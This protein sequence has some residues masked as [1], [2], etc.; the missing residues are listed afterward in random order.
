[1]EQTKIGI[2]GCGWLG[3]PLAEF[4]ISKNYLIKGSTKTRKKLTD[5]ENKSI[6]PFLIDLPE[7]IS[8]TNNSDFFNSE[9]LII[10]IPPIDKNYN[11]NIFPHDRIIKILTEKINSSSV[12]KVIYI[13][14][15]SVYRNNNSIITEES[16]YDTS[17][18]ARTLLNA[19][20]L[21]QKSR[22]NTT[23]LR[24]GG[25]YGYGR[26]PIRKNTNPV[27]LDNYRKLNLLHRDN[28]CNVILEIIE[29]NLWDETF[30]VCEDEHP[31]QLEFFHQSTAS[32]EIDNYKID[33]SKKDYKI[34][35]NFKLRNELGISLTDKISQS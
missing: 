2:L 6:I 20:S 12:K 30:N 14:S 8:N 5:L 13:S 18:R 35:S 28:G 32:S 3:L 4:L 29:K 21:L 31:T 9:I 16:D 1:M 25:L 24:F 22:F 19:E 17:L 26:I 23:V 10:N 7:G 15:T 27:I 33:N 11:G 34:V